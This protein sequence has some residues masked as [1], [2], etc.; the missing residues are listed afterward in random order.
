MYTIEH[1]TKLEV[2]RLTEVDLSARF[3]SSKNSTN[4]F[5]TGMAKEAKKK[6]KFSKNTIK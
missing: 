6:R 3:K 5:L 4:T 2:E 1:L